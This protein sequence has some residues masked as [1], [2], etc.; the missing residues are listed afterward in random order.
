MIH[1]IN[2]NNVHVC[3][4][5]QSLAPEF[6]LQRGDIIMSING[7]SL[8]NK[9]HNEAVEIMKSLSTTNIVRLELIQGEE[10]FEEEGGVSPDWKIWMERYT[11]ERNK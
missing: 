10:L 1:V 4:L 11:L 8:T 2:C 6:C 3:W 9:T 7:T 5:K